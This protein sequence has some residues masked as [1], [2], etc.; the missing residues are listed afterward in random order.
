MFTKLD[1]IKIVCNAAKIYHKKLVNK[2]FLVIY[3]NRSHNAIECFEILF[4][5]ETFCT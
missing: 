4:C 5:Q 2:N 1:A 3:K